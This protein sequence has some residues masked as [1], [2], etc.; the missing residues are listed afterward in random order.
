VRAEG[1]NNITVECRWIPKSALTRP[2]RV[3][4]VHLLL[5]MRTR[6]PTQQ[7][8]GPQYFFLLLRRFY[9]LLLLLLFWFS[10][11]PTIIMYSLWILL[12]P[13]LG[14][15]WVGLFY[16]SEAVARYCN[17]RVSGIAHFTGK[18]IFIISIHNFIFIYKIRYP[19]W[20][21]HVGKVKTMI[22]SGLTFS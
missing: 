4:R 6:V 19:Y 1:S 8:V 21:I 17:S 15:R 16:Y 7:V 18:R 10:A 9:L 2:R 14:I 3:R 12:H 5:V 13:H 11:I 22:V 20:S